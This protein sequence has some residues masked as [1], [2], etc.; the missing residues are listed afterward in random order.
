MM[1]Q[2]SM[3]F[4]ISRALIFAATCAPLTIANGRVE[5]Q[6]LTL[7]NG[8]YDVGTTVCKDGYSLDGSHSSTCQNTGTWNPQSPQC[9]QSNE[10][11]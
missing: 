9:I 5:T 6:E 11:N 10:I 2:A 3:Y 8:R 1:K 4:F 7:S